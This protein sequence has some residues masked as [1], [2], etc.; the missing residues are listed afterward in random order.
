MKKLAVVI[1]CLAFAVPESAQSLGEKIG[2]SAIIGVAP[3]TNDF[4]AQAAIGDIFGIEAGKLALAR[5]GDKAKSF[6]EKIVK[7]HEDSSQ[8]LKALIAGG[9]VR[10]TAPTAVDSPR[11]AVLDK[12][13]K[14]QGAEFDKEFS[15][16]QASAQAETLSLFQRYSKDGDHPDLKLYAVKRL[17]GLEERT[18]L[19]KDL[20][21]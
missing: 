12:L 21:N 15:E 4:I 6:A 1:A 16:T 19:A 17:P 20:K 14:L 9:N 2:I 3:T 18:R 8:A 5:G 13:A 10:A 11:R 7:D